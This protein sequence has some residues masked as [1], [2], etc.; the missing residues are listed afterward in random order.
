MRPLDLLELP[1]A[2]LA[3][4]L[5]QQELVARF[6]MSAMRGQ[7]LQTILDEA[8]AV[9]AQGLEVRFAK[10]LE[11][12]PG[13]GAFL[14]RAGVGWKPG[15][16]GE[17]RLG[18]DLASPAG[19]AFWTGQPVISNHLGSETRFRTPALLTEHGVH[20]AL[21]VLV[22][23]GDSSP[24]GVLEVDS[25]E[26]GDFGAADAAFLQGLANTLAAA[27]EMA[28]RQDARDRLL[29]EKDLLMQEVH[30][31]VKNSL[32]LVQTLLQL[33]A[34][35]LTSAEAKRQVE[36][37][38]GRIATIG[39]VHRR[40]YEGGSVAEVDAA[41]YLR[42]L[43]EDMRGMLAVAGNART[44]ELDVAPMTLAADHVTPLGLVTS[45]LVTNA[46]KYSSG[47]V[48]VA[49]RR[50]AGGL[51]VVVEDEGTGFPADFDPARSSGLGMRLVNALSKAGAD[52]IA[53]DR[54][55]PFGRVVV[56][57]RLDEPG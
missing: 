54:S 26:R 5:R 30:H 35:N 55:V 44:V 21:N 11:F 3:L 7:D 39:A 18:G 31:R 50:T 12:L 6:G 10:V 51:E 23:V 48:R 22:R 28:A 38:A 53:V 40:L 19:Y 41:A 52:A 25:T 4:R 27:L 34:R 15:V 42:G 46:M 45:E 32:Q 16:V 14:V 20:S 57:L 8:S 24:F 9:A 17:A 56:Q 47:R 36:E 43:I 37:A 29:R 33:Q 49:V 13:E 1:P 2:E